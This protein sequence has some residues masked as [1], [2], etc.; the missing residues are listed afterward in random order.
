MVDGGSNKIQIPDDGHYRISF[1][2][3]V[4]GED[5]GYATLILQDENS[6]NLAVVEMEAQC[7]HDKF[8]ST[9]KIEIPVSFVVYANLNR[10]SELYLRLKTNK[11]REYSKDRNLFSG[12]LQIEQLSEANLMTTT[13]ARTYDEKTAGVV[14]DLFLDESCYSPD[15]GGAQGL[16]KRGNSIEI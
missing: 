11:F 10:G 6:N 4:G 13:C 12:Q 7:N 8:R 1:S 3:V 5:E 2:G 9:T 14:K 16:I 15:I